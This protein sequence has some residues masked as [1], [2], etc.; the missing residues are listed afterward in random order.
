MVARF[1][2]RSGAE[3]IEDEMRIVER[4][5]KAFFPGF[6]SAF[7]ELKEQNAPSPSECPDR[8][9]ERAGGFS[10]AVSGDGQ[11]K[12]SAFRCDVCLVLHCIASP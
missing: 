6:A 1:P 8:D 7:D 9:A 3:L 10:F 11:Q 12:P 5:E 2:C 4:I